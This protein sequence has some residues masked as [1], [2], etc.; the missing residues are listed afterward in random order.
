MK[1]RLQ[2]F[3]I[4]IFLCYTAFAMSLGQGISSIASKSLFPKVSRALI[5]RL[6]Q[7]AKE[8]TVV[9][10]TGKRSTEKLLERMIMRAKKGFDPSRQDLSVLDDY[11][12]LNDHGV[13]NFAEAEGY[14]FLDEKV[15]HTLLYYVLKNNSTL[16]GHKGILRD[17]YSRGAQLNMDDKKVMGSEKVLKTYLN[18]PI[19]ASAAHTIKVLRT[20]LT[21]N[22]PE[23][24]EK[25]FSSFGILR[26]EGKKRFAKLADV[27]ELCQ[28]VESDLLAQKQ[29]EMMQ[30]RKN[31]YFQFDEL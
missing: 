5:K 11:S 20:F 2:Y 30:A 1:K 4:G 25:R 7:E 16:S 8:K 12:F 6:N 23:K 15:R 29:K 13:L 24:I 28:Q 21:K 14:T 31:K 27:Q 10:F 18:L 22:T 3:I 19:D 26:L 17:L 9:S